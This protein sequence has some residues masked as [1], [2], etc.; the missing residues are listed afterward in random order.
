MSKAFNAALDM[1]FIK[2]DVIAE[3]ASTVHKPK[4][5]YLNTSKK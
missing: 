1:T 3:L 4:K 2:I 5:E